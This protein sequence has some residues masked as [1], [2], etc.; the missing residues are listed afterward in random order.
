[1][2]ES[3]IAEELLT[4]GAQILRSDKYHKAAEF[5]Q[6]ESQVLEFIMKSANKNVSPSDISKNL[7]IS[8]ARVALLLRKLENKGFIERVPDQSDSRK[9]IVSITQSGIKELQKK[10]SAAVEIIN[11]ILN[12]LEEKDQVEIL[13]ISNKFFSN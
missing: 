4:I 3:T 10:K 12:K 2:E 9:T 11:D 7:L 6:G 1:M 8:Q 5:M 13:R